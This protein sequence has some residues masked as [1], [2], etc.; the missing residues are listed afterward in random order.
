MEHT[1]LQNIV[2]KHRGEELKSTDRIMGKGEVNDIYV[3]T[4][5]SSKYV[6]RVDPSESSDERFQKESWSLGAAGKAGVLVPEVFG[7]G[8]EEKHPYILMSFI[9]GIHGADVDAESKNLIWSRLGNYAR[10]IHSVKTIGFDE[11]MISPGTFKGSWS[12]YLEYNISSLND[13]DKLLALGIITEDQSRFLRDIFLQIKNTSFNF[14]LIHN[15]LSLK[16]TIL[17]SD[18]KVYLLDWGG[19]QADVIPHMDFAEVLHFSLKE[20][21]PEFAI[22]LDGYGMTRE[23]FEKIKPDMYRLLLLRL[24]DKVRW[25]IDRKPELTESKAKEFK[26]LLLD[27]KQ[28]IR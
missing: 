21:S 11:R 8:I 18:G 13:E 4:T 9:E 27:I 19:A 17:G 10:K 5:D 2:K 7:I 3:L 22:F 20:D 6:L 12:E 28:N 23:E 15:D 16:N 25:A 26:Q 14:G 24:S 1:S